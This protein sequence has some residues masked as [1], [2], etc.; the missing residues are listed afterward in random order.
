MTGIF[1]LLVA[2]S[3][4][5]AESVIYFEAG[6]KTK[7]NIMIQGTFK[8]VSVVSF[9]VPAKDSDEEDK[10]KFYKML[11]HKMKNIQLPKSKVQDFLSKI[12]IRKHG[13]PKMAELKIKL[14]TC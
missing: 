8:N 9:D 6:N 3:T 5:M 1:V 4:K 14:T 13:Y 10:D 12:L 2:V 11:E 7:W